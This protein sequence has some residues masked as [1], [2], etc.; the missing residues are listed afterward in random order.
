VRNELK[1]V[2]ECGLEEFRKEGGTECAVG[3]P[4]IGIEDDWLSSLSA[5]IFDKKSGTSISIRWQSVM[6]QVMHRRLT[7][8]TWQEEAQRFFQRYP[9]FDNEA[10]AKT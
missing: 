7:M 9:V 8:T 10:L 1:C 4:N 3:I 5:A 2:M 6:Q